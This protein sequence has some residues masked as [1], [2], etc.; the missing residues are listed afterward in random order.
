MLFDTKLLEE[1][2]SPNFSPT[3]RFFDWLK[4]TLTIGYTQPQSD[5]A[6]D[7]LESDDIDFAIRPTGGRAVLHWDE[8]TYSVVLPR[9]HPICELT[10]T[11]SYR[12]LS[13]ALAIGLKNLGIESDMSRGESGGHRNPSC[14]SS[15]SRYELTVGGKKLVGSAQRRLAGAILQQGSMPIT[16][17]FRLL[18]K[19]LNSPQPQQELA[20]HATC[21]SECSTKS[22]SKEDL[23]MSLIG[24]FCEYFDI[25]LEEI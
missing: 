6:F 9:E 14:F 16:P 4:P 13:R 2:A 10:V 8:I 18:S 7:K 24:G 12:E 22:F 25:S 3:L 19:F 11:E 5:I 15:I 23:I 21:I 1:A 17:K 20:E